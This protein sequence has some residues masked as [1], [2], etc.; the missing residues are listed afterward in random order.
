LKKK[1]KKK[2]YKFINPHKNLTFGF[3][4]A[5]IKIQAIILTNRN[6]NKKTNYN[7]IT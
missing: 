1:K 4:I 6:E 2:N 7:I 5:V 3:K